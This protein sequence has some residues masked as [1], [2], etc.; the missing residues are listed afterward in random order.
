MSNFYIIKKLYKKRNYREVSKYTK[1]RFCT[2]SRFVLKETTVCIFPQE[3]YFGKI[4]G[5]GSGI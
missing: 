1:I 4:G 5:K 2:L 3:K